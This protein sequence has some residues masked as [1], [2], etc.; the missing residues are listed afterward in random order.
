MINDGD[1]YTDDEEDGDGHDL[2]HLAACCGTDSDAWA[3]LE[4]ISRLDTRLLAFDAVADAIEWAPTRTLEAIATVLKVAVDQGW[5]TDDT[6]GPDTWSDF[7]RTWRSEESDSEEA[8]ETGLHPCGAASAPLTIPQL[9]HRPYP[10]NRAEDPTLG[11]DSFAQALAEDQV[12]AMTLNLISHVSITDVDPVDPSRFRATI[13]QGL[14][15]TH[16][17][18]YLI[19]SCGARIRYLLTVEGHE[20]VMYVDQRIS[21][22][23]ARAAGGRAIHDYPS[24]DSHAQIDGHIVC[25]G[26]LIAAGGKI[27]HIDNQSGSYQPTGR[28]LAAVVRLTLRLGILSDRAEFAQFLTSAEG[29]DVDSGDLRTLLSPEVWKRLQANGSCG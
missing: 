1:W 26:D 4:E 5:I 29:F 24:L 15:R 2:R 27:V 28:H 23:D 20:P 3:F 21:G 22:P 18:M 6:P 8:A 10:G 25:A 19:D 9:G 17:G 14:L 11:T 13:D 16:D 12:D 7:L